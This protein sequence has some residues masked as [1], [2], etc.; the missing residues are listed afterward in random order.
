MRPEV[1]NVD[2]QMAAEWLK[3]NIPNNR[4]ISKAKEYDF[5]MR[6]GNWLT[7]HQG[8]AFDTNGNLID[9]QN[10]LTA[11][12]SS[13]ITIEMLVV[14]DCD[15]KSL[16]VL[17]TGRKRTLGDTLKI[18]GYKNWNNLAGII[19]RV[20]AYEAGKR[21]VLSPQK[22]NGEV[23]AGGYKSSTRMDLINFFENNKDEILQC[24]DF[25]LMVYHRSSSRLVAS[26]DIGL[27]YWIFKM[28]DDANEFISKICIG[29]NISPDT[30]EYH[31]RR[32]LEENKN[33]IRSLSSATLLRYW[34]AAWEKRNIP[35]K[36]LRLKQ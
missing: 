19:G 15:P 14:F 23:G 29:I 5:D 32:V 31:M 2:P 27:L 28:S 25:A 7:T 30:S 16:E 36:T 13:G 24:A 20:Q 18:G 6:M 26:A 33:N 22:N 3:K 35:V 1:I 11:I 17:D 34:L 21:S 8:I 9:G 10:R 12:V 4:S